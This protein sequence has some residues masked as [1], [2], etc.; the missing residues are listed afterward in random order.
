[1][2][3]MPS[4]GQ[5]G[6]D[7][8][9]LEPRELVGG[10]RFS[11]SGSHRSDGMFVLAANGVEAGKG[12]ADIADMAPTMLAACGLAVPSSMEGRSLLPPPGTARPLPELETAVDEE[13][14]PASDEQVLEERLR[15]LGY[16][17]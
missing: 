8:R 11:M 10:K 12:D 6:P 14:Y 4:R 7:T 15:A 2:C 13:F 5:A 1:Y 16:L 9:R 17:G 3:T